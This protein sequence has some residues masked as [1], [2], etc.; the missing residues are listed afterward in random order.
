MSGKRTAKHAEEIGIPRK[1]SSWMYFTIG[2]ASVVLRIVT[3]KFLDMFLVSRLRL[4]QISLTVYAIANFLVPLT[5]KFFV[6]IMYALVSGICDGIYATAINCI[7]TKKYAGMGF[8]WFLCFQGVSLLI[9][10]I[11]AGMNLA[12][13]ISLCLN[14]QTYDKSSGFST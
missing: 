2:I 13:T 9:T 11:L 8:G 5:S 14:I 1:R 12:Q 3:G 7:V 10:P 6:L 4:Y